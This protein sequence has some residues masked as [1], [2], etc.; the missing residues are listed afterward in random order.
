MQVITQ[1]GGFYL[2]LAAHDWRRPVENLT[3]DRFLGAPETAACS[4]AR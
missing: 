3:D 1:H 2:G 4:T